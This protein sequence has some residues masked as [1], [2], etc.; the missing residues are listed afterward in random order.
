MAERT[1]PQAAA[2]CDERTARVIVKFRPSAASLRAHALS[3]T[4]SG[5]RFVRLDER[6]GALGR[7]FRPAIAGRPGLT[8]RVQVVQADGVDARTLA[9]RLAQDADV[10]YAE[11]DRRMRRVLVPND[12]RFASVAATGS[13]GGPAVGQWYLRAPAGAVASSI[14]AVSAWDTSTGSASIVVAV[15]DTGVRTDHPDLAGKLLPGYDMV[16][17]VAIS[18]DGNGRDTDASDPGDWL[19][20]TE[21]DAD[22]LAHPNP[23]D[24]TFEGCEAS[25]QLVARHAG[26]RNRRRGHQ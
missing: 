21:I 2:R 4:A 1:P 16:D 17:D 15:L 23:L 6:A 19:T 25:L 12:A 20:Q 3:A 8:D 18:N 13:S 26:F 7:T 22:A 5:P 14:D 11:V 10:E 9:A 24:R